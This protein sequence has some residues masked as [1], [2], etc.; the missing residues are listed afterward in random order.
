MDKVQEVKKMG[1]QKVT[2]QSRGSGGGGV[3]IT[4]MLHSIIPPFVRWTMRAGG[5][6]L[7]RIGVLLEPAETP[8]NPQVSDKTGFTQ[9]LFLPIFYFRITSLL[10]YWDVNNNL[11][12]RS[13]GITKRGDEFWRQL[14]LERVFG[15]GPCCS[16][17][18][19]LG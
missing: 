17:V 10:V 16:G 13:N 7:K 19:C 14:L 18:R 6:G 5:R 9:N 12:W 4:H 2:T 3:T 11:R 1:G 8:A 15:D